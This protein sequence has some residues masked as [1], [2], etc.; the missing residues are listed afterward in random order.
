MSTEPLGNGTLKEAPFKNLVLKKGTFQASRGG[1]SWA[2]RWLSEFGLRTE[3]RRVETPE[4]LASAWRVCRPG[5]PAGLALLRKV[6]SRL[7][8]S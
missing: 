1:C 8:G 7:F 3:L 5:N 6:C 2:W 4:K